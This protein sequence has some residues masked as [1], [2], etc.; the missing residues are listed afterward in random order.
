MVSL[1]R[2]PRHPLFSRKE[3]NKL[4][5]PEFDVP[6]CGGDCLATGNP[7]LSSIPADVAPG[8]PNA[9]AFKT[10]IVPKTGHGLN[11]EYSHEMTYHT[12]QKFLVGNGL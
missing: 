8:F 6:F 1:S 10:F 4:I 9:S 7:A 2:L 12:A 5:L 11:L 3:A